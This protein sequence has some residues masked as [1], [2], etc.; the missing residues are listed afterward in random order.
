MFILTE[1]RKNKSAFDIDT[2]NEYL[3]INSKNVMGENKVFMRIMIQHTPIRELYGKT[4]V[5]FW[6]QLMSV[7]I[8]KGIAAKNISVMDFFSGEFSND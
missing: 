1:D 6:N 4:A 7:A 2:G 5:S 8:N 3:L